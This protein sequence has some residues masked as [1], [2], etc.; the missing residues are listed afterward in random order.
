MDDYDYKWLMRNIAAPFS[1]TV[2]QIL[3]VTLLHISSAFFFL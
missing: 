2:N 1:R 3:N